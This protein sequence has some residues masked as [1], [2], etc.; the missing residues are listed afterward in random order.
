MSDPRDPDQNDDDQDDD[1]DVDTDF[2]LGD[3]LKG[4]Q[5]KSNKL[6]ELR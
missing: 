4:F 2:K 1:D 5:E 6:K 3:L